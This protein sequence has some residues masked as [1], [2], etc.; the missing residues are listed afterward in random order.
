MR[1]AEFI[2]RAFFERGWA[3][4][5]EEI[6]GWL[7]LCWSSLRYEDPAEFVRVCRL[8][9]DE[10][11]ATDRLVAVRQRFLMPPSV[12]IDGQAPKRRSRA[13]VGKVVI[14]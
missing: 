8:L 14:E 2:A 7:E 9:R 4:A 10:D 5:A 3:E 12:R 6:E 13:R 1:N 11:A